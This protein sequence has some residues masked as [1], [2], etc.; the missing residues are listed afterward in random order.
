MD[1]DLLERISNVPGV[2]GHE[3][4]AQD[5]VT[6]EMRDHCDELYEDRIGNIIGVKRAT[7]KVEG[8]RPLRVVIAAH[9]DE[10]GFIVRQINGDG[11]IKV[12]M[13]SGADPSSLMGH[14]IVIR[15]KEDVVGV[16]APKRGK[17][18]KGK[19]HI[20]ETADMG[21]GKGATIGGVAGG[22]IGAIAGAAL[23]G[24]VLVGALVGGLAAKLKD[25]GFDNDRKLGDEKGSRTPF[26][27]AGAPTPPVQAPPGS[28]ALR[29]PANS[30]TN[31]S[32]RG[33]SA[34]SNSSR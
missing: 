12:G 19:L 26:G 10:F 33:S 24:P 16:L 21:G 30:A 8:E 3:K 6:A 7:E 22:V 17:D 28:G 18:D 5:L 13:M 14:Q 31:C 20:K 29:L 11:F 32:S 34:L 9:V 27:Q 1:F 4:A 15:G 23:A 2:S 25:S